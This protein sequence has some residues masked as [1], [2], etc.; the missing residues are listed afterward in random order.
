MKKTRMFLVCLIVGAFVLSA[1]IPMNASAEVTK[2]EWEEGR[3]WSFGFEKDLDTHMDSSSNLGGGLMGSGSGIESMKF[4]LDGEVG[5]YQ[6]YKVTDVTDE[7]YTM[8]IEAGGGIHIDGSFSVKGDFPKEGE[9]TV[10]LSDY[11]GMDQNIPKEEMEMSGEGGL[12]VVITIEGYAYFERDTMAMEEVHLDISVE[13]EGNFEGKNIPGG[14]SSMMGTSYS[15]SDD[16][17]NYEITY[18]YEDV[19][20]DMSGSIHATLDMVVEDGMNM[21]EFPFGVDDQWTIDT[22]ATISGSYSGEIDASGLPSMIEGSIDDENMTFPITIE[23]MDMGEEHVDNGIIEEHTQV[24]KL[25]AEC[26]GTSEV[27]LEDGTTGTAYIVEYTL[28]DTE[29]SSDEEDYKAGYAEGY[30]EGQEDDENGTFGYDYDSYDYDTYYSGYISG[31]NAGYYGWEYD[32]TYTSYEYDYEQEMTLFELQYCPENEFMM[33]GGMTSISEGMAGDMT[34]DM[35]TEMDMI[36]GLAGVN[37]DDMTM[38]PISESEAQE[39]MDSITAMPEDEGS[40]IPALFSPPLIY[41]LLGVIVIVALLAVLGLKKS[42]GSKQPDYPPPPQQPYQQQNTD[43]YQ[44]GESGQNTDERWGPLNEN[45]ESGIS[46]DE[47]I[48]E[49]GM[50]ERGPRDY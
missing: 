41:I 15:M 32:D 34:G 31:Y 19:D 42:G 38:K 7:R 30:A 18:E 43:R 8:D 46:K 6:I 48:S 27:E 22:N 40:S 21:L 5:F 33:P 37:E 44:Q 49:D 9:Y 12:D 29:T 4:D 16:Y 3:S 26:T 10:N 47:N 2:P 1:L 20:A 28:A 24:I 39:K 50:L 23:D 35:G 17:E 13:M 36:S 25:N 11:E 45:D 14:D